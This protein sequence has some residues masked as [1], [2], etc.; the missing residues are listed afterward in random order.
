MK[1]ARQSQVLVLTQGMAT[2]EL[3]L[4]GIFCSEFVADTVQKLDVALLRV[5]LHSIDESP[6]HC[7]SSLCSDRSIGSVRLSQLL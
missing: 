7:A 4:L 5:F 2:A 3:R 6:R 1:Q